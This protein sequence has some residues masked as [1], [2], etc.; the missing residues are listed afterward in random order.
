[1]QLADADND[2]K[3][4]FVEFC[5][6]VRNRE[7]GEFTDDELKQRFEALDHDGSHDKSG[8]IDKKEFHKAVLELGFDVHRDVADAVFA[9]LDDDHSGALEYKELNHM[10]R[11]GAGSEKAKANL[12]RGQ[13]KLPDHETATEVRAVPVI[14]E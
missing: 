1:M 10:L 4:D 7:E 5:A 6:F 8:T 13:S 14:T 3:L 2:G 9:S 11:K 12:K